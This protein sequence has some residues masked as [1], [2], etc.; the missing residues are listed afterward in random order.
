MKYLIE[1]N[2][3]TFIIDQKQ[4]TDDFFDFYHISRKKRYLMHQNQQVKLNDKVIKQA[5]PLNSGDK[6]AIEVFID[7]PIDFICENQSVDIVYE[8]EIILIAN[9][10]AGIIVH[11]DSKDGN[12]TLAN[13]IAHYYQ[14]TNQNHTIRAIHR[15]DLE[16]SGLVLFCKCPFFQPLLDH[17]LSEKKIGRNYYAFVEG[18]LPL[19]QKKIINAPIGADRHVNNRYRISPKGK[20]AI[21]EYECL[22]VFGTYSLVSCTLQTGRTHQIRVHMQSIKH[23]LLSDK[24]Y[25]KTHPLINRCALH[26]YELHF[27][28]PLTLKEITV[29]K[30][31]P[32]DMKKLE[33]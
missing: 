6:L 19:H 15:L 9:K 21:T 30:E 28:H 1:D 32:E 24:I 18:K 17:L 11:P 4:S 16:T 10:P 23:P 5:M 8:D 33:K 7:E 3:I 25:G 20:S 29:Q 31:M 2:W 22:K 12:H 13:R 27:I 26:A 14:S